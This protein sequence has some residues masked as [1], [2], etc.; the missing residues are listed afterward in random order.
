MKRVLHFPLLRALL[1]LWLILS[2]FYSDVFAQNPTE[3]LLSG[4]I[5]G[6][7]GK[8]M[9]GVS[10]IL[11]GTQT[12]TATDATGKYQ[13]RVSPR[14]VL[15]F[16]FVGYESQEIVVGNR[17]SLD[18]TL[19]PDAQALNEV[20]VVGY[21]V[22]KKRDLTG[23]VATVSSKQIQQVPVT[24]VVQALQGR[25]A[26]VDVATADY[27][28][29]ESAS[30]RIRG[31]RSF[32]ASNEPLYVVDGVPLAGGN[33]NDFN[34]GDI[35]SL[36]ILKDASATAIYGS[37]GANGVIL[38]TTKRGKAG[39]TS[40]TYDSFFGVQ[41][42]SK[43]L[44][45][46]DGAGHAE[47]IRES[48]RNRLT[49]FIYKSPTPNRAEDSTILAP[50][51]FYMWQSVRAAY[52]PDGSYHPERVRNTD[53]PGFVLQQS[54]LQSHQISAAGGGEKTR[55][56]ISGALF[57]DNGIMKGKDFNRY[58][59]RFN[60][61]HDV[62][63]R[64][65]V[66][67][68]NTFAYS[69]QNK[70]QNLY[71]Q[72]HR[73]SPLTIPVDSLG[74]DIL[75]PGND[76]NIYNAILDI[77]GVKR[78]ERNTRFFGSFYGEVDLLKG[79]KFRVNFGPDFSMT[80]NGV[81]FAA[82]S[83][84]G[85][86][87][88]S[89]A[90]YNQTNRFS[91]TLENLLFYNRRFKDAHDLGITLLQSA[92]EERVEGSGGTVT[93]LPYERQ[94]FYNLGT[95]QNITGISSN[96]SRWRL[97]SY[98]GRVNYNFKSKYYLTLTGRIDGSS[99]LADGNKYSFF[100]SASLAYNVA[101]EPFMRKVSFIDELKIR[102]GYGETGNTSISPYQTQGSL[103]RTTY[104]WDEVAAFG[105]RPGSIVNSALRWERT[106]AFNIGLDFSFWRSRIAGSLNIYRANTYDL[107]LRDQLPTASGFDNY[108]RN[109]GSTQN[110]GIELNL[111]THNIRTQGGLQW[112]TDWMFSR[113]RE[114]IVELYKGKVD[115]I[116]NLWFIGQPLSVVYDYKI[117]RIWQNTPEDLALLAEY[118]RRGNNG[119]RPGDIKPVDINNDGLINV[120]DR[121]I[122]GT[123]RPAWYGGMT[124][125]ISY[126]GLE[127][128][129]FAYTRQRFLTSTDI[130]GLSNFLTGNVNQVVVD[131][132]TPSNPTGTFP[133]PSERVFPLY[134]NSMKAVD[135]SFVRIRT[136]T[137]AYTF[138]TAFANRLKMNRLRS[139][140]TAD[141]PFIFN[142]DKRIL[143]PE[144]AGAAETPNR[145][146]ILFGLNI[147]L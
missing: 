59:T 9:P 18:L 96:F 54:A 72:A 137:L 125:T 138:P 43:R 51:D 4:V 85:K 33:L 31:N 46:Y 66:G 120:A 10:I 48:F 69:I 35:E 134:S 130:Y 40:I 34:P 24:N 67:F 1:P 62:S 19:A 29:G 27:G 107:L 84:E 87:G 88:S 126:K 80:R 39:K 56:L 116:G 15:V 32:T 21:G 129:V 122:L 139:Y 60:V 91:Y 93:N 26:G 135:G 141:N 83:S 68:S 58:T 121:T 42:P 95:A 123:D 52:D 57:S 36:E 128:S 13:I 108:L 106:A 3:S 11:K 143:D 8:P 136:M 14:S 97:L 73:A 110:N 89:T 79:L 105:Y 75:N 132:W 5:R 47:L 101:E 70:G 104:S 17:T 99:R 98:M 131:Y 111:T 90:Q 53:W 74:R 22:Q 16:S 37:R 124:N 94:K 100:P 114:Q 6:E 133:R 142:K 146:A 127:F 20:V 64:V 12:G 50:K 119:F 23:A 65:R 63:K 55:F 117:D 76:A 145:T 41:F 109:V 118:N 92:Q 102:A 147:G 25:A 71:Y 86:G 82:Q 112:T 140:I 113:N 38:I 144:G 28:P 7:D 30:I 115:D 61:D 103:T 78:E 44:E 45:L 81:F 49:G 2:V 77:N